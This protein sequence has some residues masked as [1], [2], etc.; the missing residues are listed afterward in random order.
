MTTQTTTADTRDDLDRHGLTEP[1]DERMAYGYAR[2]EQGYTG[3]Y[4]DWL[5]LD[6]T[7]RQSYEDGA[8]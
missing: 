3:S 5:A 1:A 6:T 7:D 4:D 8:R 2:A